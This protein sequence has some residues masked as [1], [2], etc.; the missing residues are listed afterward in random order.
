LALARQVGNQHLLGQVLYTS[1]AVLGEM[2][3]RSQAE[4]CLQEGLTVQR[5]QGYRMD[6]QRTLIY[7]SRLR[8]EDNDYQRGRGYLAEAMHLLQLIDNRPAEARIVNTLGYVEAMLGN[9]P[10]ALEHHAASRRISQ[11]I[12]QPMQESHA[13]HNLC[14]V[15]R[16]MG[17]LQQAEASGEEALRLALVYDFPDAANYARLH[18]GYVWLACGDLEEAAT[19][20]QLARDSW[21]SQQRINLALEASVGLAA[22][23]YRSG[24]LAQAAT[25]IAPVTPIL[26]TRVI[27]GA[28]EP[29]EMY[30]TC[31][32]ILSAQQDS[33]AEA[34]LAT[35]YTY[36]QS[37]ASKITDKQLRHSFWPTVPTHRQIR[38][39]WQRTPRKVS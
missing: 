31:Y 11:E 13:L 22:V 20:F 33:L 4:A 32:Q 12:H 2:D 5:Q 24:N 15:H 8:I 25:L 14:T 26:A 39:L 23:A 10:A 35:A 38:A 3:E 36:L 1:G 27:E 9:Y 17:N 34:L 28:D 6:E 30:L 18:L 7:L 21:Q 37:L 29:F 16:K 19:A